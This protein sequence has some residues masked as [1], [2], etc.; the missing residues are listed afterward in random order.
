MAFIGTINSDIHFRNRIIN[1]AMDIDQRCNNFTTSA[2]TVV[3]ASAPYTL[4]R[5]RVQC[6][7][8]SGTMNVRQDSA[9]TLV[10]GFVNSMRAIVTAAN[11]SMPSGG[12]TRVFTSLEGNSISDFNW[13]TANAQSVTLSFWVRSSNTG[14]FSGSVTNYAEDRSYPFTYTINTA[15]N[16]EK[17]IIT[18]PGDTSGTWPTSNA[19]AL[20]INFDLGS[21][22]TQYGTAN[23]WTGSFKTGVT[24]STSL[25][26]VA[27]N[28][29]YL[30]GVQLE[31][32]STAT[33]FERRPYGT[34]FQLCQRYYQKIWGGGG[35]ASSSTGWETYIHFPVP[36]RGVPS[37]S[38]PDGVSTIEDHAVTAY[39]QSS[40]SATL[41]GGRPF[42][43]KLILGN[44]SS[45]SGS[46]YYSFAGTFFSRPIHF[47]AEI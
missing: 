1:G 18:I 30:T 3:S 2:N 25:M 29:W 8:H 19:G 14:T 15:N 27:G 28:N 13:G 5:F 43:G 36:M 23:A 44:F 21:G 41:S 26:G 10:T 47:Q 45:L 17:E 12:L 34:E 39:T 6:A 35:S 32:G 20:V 7:N 4:D 38:Q 24:G 9:N 31:E 40:T 37:I 33:P 11:T 46:R 22:S 42:G 16:W